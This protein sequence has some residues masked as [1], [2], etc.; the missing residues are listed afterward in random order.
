MPRS[1]SPRNGVA[2]QRRDFGGEPRCNR[3]RRRGRDRACVKSYRFYGS[4]GGRKQPFAFRHAFAM[5]LA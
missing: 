4:N 2:A 3:D 1:P 5:S